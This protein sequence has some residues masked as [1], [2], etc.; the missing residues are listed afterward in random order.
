[1]GMVSPK[2]FL[3]IV[4]ST[5]LMVRDIQGRYQVATAEQVLEAARQVIDLKTPRGAAFGSPG[6]VKSYLCTKLAGYEHEVFA[7]LFLTCQHQ[8]IAYH[9]LFQGT[10]NQAAVYPREVVKKALQLN[11]AAVIL[12]HN[13]PSGRPEPSKY[14]EKLTRTLSTALDL[15]NVKTL[16]HII[17]GGLD[18]ISFHEYGLL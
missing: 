2:L 10:I 13:H 1:M 18:C 5:E 9:E 11:A 12:A 14:D 6:D 4:M 15:V 3:E 17:V 8:L 16:D 7:A